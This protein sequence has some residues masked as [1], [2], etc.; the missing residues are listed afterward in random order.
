[1]RPKILKKYNQISRG[2]KNKRNATGGMQPTCNTMLDHASK[3]ARC[4][5]NW[6][7][8]NPDFFPTYLGSEREEI[9]TNW[10]QNRWNLFVSESK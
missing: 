10:G 1:M 3:A 9:P 2:R 4:I 6:I 5:P 7:N 8:H